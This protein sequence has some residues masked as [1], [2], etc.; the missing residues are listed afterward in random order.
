MRYSAAGQAF[1]ALH[2][3]LVQHDE[4]GKDQ[5]STDKSGWHQFQPSRRQTTKQPRR[6]RLRYSC[7][8]RG[9][10][11]ELAAQR[12]GNDYARRCSPAESADDAGE[13]CCPELAVPVHI[14]SH[15]NL[16]SGDIH[17][18]AGSGQSGISSI[19]FGICPA[20]ADQS[21]CAKSA[22]TTPPQVPLRCAD[23]KQPLRPCLGA[24]NAEGGKSKMVRGDR[25]Q[26]ACR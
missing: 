26:N 18:D 12:C 3:P 15:G 2:Q 4:T 5:Y 13:A 8:S 11:E 17:N 22:G 6:S 23:K 9:S 21:T 10:V 16:E 14:L 1:A 20:I 19:M 7:H 25:E 24:G